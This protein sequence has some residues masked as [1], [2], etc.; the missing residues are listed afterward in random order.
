[1]TAV[2]AGV[3]ALGFVFHEQN[4][5][6]IDPEGAKAILE[7]LPPFVDTV[8]VFVDKKRKEAEEIIAYCRLDYV[9]LHGEESPKYCERLARFSSPCALL[10][11]FRGGPEFRP[12]SMADYAPFVK[13]FLLDIST[14]MEKR[15]GGEV[16]DKSAM[17]SLSTL[18][19]CLLA[20]SLDVSNITQALKTFQPFGV[21]ANVGIEKKPGV[22]DYQLMDA[23][24]QK[25]R[26][27]E[28][29]KLMQQE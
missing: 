3:D 11:A 19:P 26:L 6:Y 14:N 16:F 20:G 10:K 9:Q 21:D 12:E 13:G 2:R 28:Q 23:F 25:I 17:A 8:G 18:R 7:E 29:Q 15:G 22:K 24:L 5:R 4:P 27:F 1:M